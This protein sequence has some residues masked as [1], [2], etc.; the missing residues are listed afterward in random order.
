MHI[1]FVWILNKYFLY[2]FP[3]MEDRTRIITDDGVV[4][5]RHFNQV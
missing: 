1:Q 2:Y 3:L 5:T 4:H